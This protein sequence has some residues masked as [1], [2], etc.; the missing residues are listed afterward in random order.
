M[1]KDREGFS[2][3][4][5]TIK[6]AHVFIRDGE[7]L[8]SAMKRSGKFGTKFSPKETEQLRKQGREARAREIDKINKMSQEEY[9]KTPEDYKGTLK[10]LVDTAEFRGENKEELRAFY[11]KQGYNVDKDKTVLKY[12]NGGT[13]LQPVKIDD[14]YATDYDF[15]KSRHIG[16][17][18][19]NKDGIPVYDNKI[20]NKGDFGYADLSKLSNEELKQALNVQSQEYKNATNERLGDQRTRNGKMDKIFNTAKKQKY[21][22][23]MKLLNEEIDKRDLPRYNIYDDAGNIR[24][25]S[26]TKEMA[27]RELAEMYETDKSLQK[28]YGW[29]ELPKYSIKEGKVDEYLNE[30][31]TTEEKAPYDSKAYAKLL[32]KNYNADSEYEDK[33]TPKYIQDIDAGR[34]GNMSDEEAIKNWIDGGADII[35]NDDAENILKSWGV[36]VRNDDAYGTYKSELA[37]QL[38]P[39][40]RSDKKNASLPKMSL[41]ELRNMANDYGLDTKGKS[42]KQLLSALISMFNK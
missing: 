41:S 42:K 21:E 28:S 25:S 37:K 27:E 36:P 23:G 31:K 19:F 10:E 4:W 16:F 17:G 20:D 3:V 35:Y 9:D 22:E 14:K 7:D 1:A 39:I 38:A 12:D 29:K 32:S 18:E 6:G 13:V 8:D 2:G 11:E 34:Y 24:V 30:R 40:Y 5:R 33:I 26:P 15:A